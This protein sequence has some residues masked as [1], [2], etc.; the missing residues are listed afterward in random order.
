[1]ITSKFIIVR[2]LFCMRNKLHLTFIKYFKE[3]LEY[4]LKRFIYN[5]KAQKSLIIIMF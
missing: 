2:S 5:L 3:N 4:Y 1:M